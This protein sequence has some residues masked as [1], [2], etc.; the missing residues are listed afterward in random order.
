VSSSASGAGRSLRGRGKP[1]E[2]SSLPHS[3][4]RPARRRVDAPHEERAV[5]SAVAA[6]AG[7]VK[8]WLKLSSGEGAWTGPRLGRAPSAVDGAAGGRSEAHNARKN[9]AGQVAVTRAATALP[10]TLRLDA[11]TCGKKLVVSQTCP[12][13]A[14]PVCAS[15]R[16]RV[17]RRSIL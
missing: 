10:A 16:G 5:E 8:P 4:P 12:A 3:E 6:P 14:P 15:V 9:A 1:W 2:A 17:R 13:A 11:G 7:T